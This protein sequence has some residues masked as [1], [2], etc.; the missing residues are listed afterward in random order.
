M[1]DFQV[2]FTLLQIWVIFGEY[3]VKHN[4]LSASHPIRGI[5]GD[6]LFVGFF[7]TFASILLGGKE[8]D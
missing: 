3:V 1:L 7:S 4:I 2:N 6:S 8:G 5:L